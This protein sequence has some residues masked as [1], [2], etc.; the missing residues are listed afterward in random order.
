MCKWGPVRGGPP[1]TPKCSL[2]RTRTASDRK[3]PWGQGQEL[4][5]LTDSGKEK[6]KLGLG[7]EDRDLGMGGKAFKERMKEMSYSSV[8]SSEKLH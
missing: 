4:A 7:G 2:N 3:S 5:G 8:G 1:A 6:E